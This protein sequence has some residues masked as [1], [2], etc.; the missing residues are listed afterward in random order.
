[1]TT[2]LTGLAAVYAAA[3]LSMDAKD[4]VSRDALSSAITAALAE[5]EK[6]GLQKAGND[7]T[8]IGADAVAAASVRC[9]TILG[10]A[11]AKGRE[12]MAHRLAFDSNM[13]ADAAIEMLK[14]APKGQSQS[15]L[16]GS[17]PDPK[18]AADENS[19]QQMDAAA[20]GAAW[21]N[22]LTKRGMKVAS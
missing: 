2:V 21:D 14:D 1:M 13:S 6:V 9:K 19:G 16:D 15:R 7:A 11:E 8:K 18:L 12:K 20:T 5:G 3:G 22:V 4:S 10:H 17:V